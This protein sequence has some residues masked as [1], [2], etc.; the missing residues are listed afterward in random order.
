MLADVTS[1]GRRS[2][3]G[4]PVW[5]LARLYP[6][7]GHWTE[8]DF[9]ELDQSSENFLAELDDGILELLPM[10]DLFHQGIVK[11]LF[12]HLDD[13]AVKST[14]AEVFTAPSPIRLWQGQLREPDIFLIMK[15]RIKDRHRP[16][17]GTDL[18]VEVVSSGSE[19]RK[20]DLTI[21]RRVY[22]KAE[23][24]E[25]W[26]V[27]PEKQRITVLKLTGKTYKTH[28]VFK[29]GDRATSKLLPGFS[30]DVAAVFAAGAG[31]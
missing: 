14:Q 9:L 11:Y 27:D 10:P 7:Q 13:H 2:R 16:P 8:D 31:K 1:N 22:A 30:V 4:E 19:N 29:P 5:E 25:Y 20:R 6:L 17:E 26:V 12:R 3:R 28:G 15:H 21:K 18:A 24:T 23:V